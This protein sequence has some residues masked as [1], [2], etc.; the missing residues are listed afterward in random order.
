MLEKAKPNPLVITTLT[1]LL[2]ISL[3]A[4][5]QATRE[6]A[7]WIYLLKQSAWAL[8]GGGMLL[9]IRQMEYRLL[10]QHADW[11]YRF[12]VLAL[13]SLFLFGKEINGARS[14]IDL[15][16]LSIQ[17]SEIARI[18]TLLMLAKLYEQL[19]GTIENVKQL[20]RVLMI[21]IIPLLLILIQ[22]DL[23][24]AL[25]YLTM[26]G[27]F[28]LLAKLPA[29]FHLVTGVTVL[30]LFGGL[31]LLHASS[32]SLFFEIIRPHQLERL[33]SFLHPEADPLGSG[34][35]YLQARKVVGSG[36]LFGIG[37]LQIDPG[38]GPHLPERHTDF[39][40]AVIAQQWG[41][42]GS[43]FLL[44]LYFLLFYRF[45]QWAIRTPDPFAAFFISGMVTMWS[46]QIFVNI[47]MN[48]GLSPITG[49]TLP[50][51]SYGGSS[52]LSNLIGVGLILSMKEPSPLWWLE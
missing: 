35:Q 34:Y 4:V 19:Q 10:V 42:V 39:I 30:L 12:G 6:Q 46:V 25:I 27:C 33:T 37:L 13:A 48:I 22:P 24:M 3:L 29:G 16:I 52:L 23:G 5:Y 49:I 20:G 38:T 51:I 11:I 15:G 2:L 28:L 45:V 50:F 9:V 36:E 43:S 44:L 21:L 18:T 8:L 17:P 40:F 1:C 26:F 47:G 41:F 14:W 7:G 31:Y 32:P